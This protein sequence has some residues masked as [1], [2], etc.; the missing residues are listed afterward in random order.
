[1]ESKWYTY[2]P[3]ATHIHEIHWTTQIWEESLFSFLQHTLWLVMG[4]V[5]KWAKNLG[6]PKEKSTKFPIFPSY[7]SCNFWIYNSH[8][9]TPYAERLCQGYDLG[10]VE[11]EEHLLL[12][13][14]N[15]QK[16][17][18]RF[19]LA[20]PLTHTN[21]LVEFMQTTNIVALAK[22]MACCQYQRIICPPWSTF[23]LMDSLVPN[24]R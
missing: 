5:L 19:C 16:I 2:E 12:V 6:I 24:G 15:T 8:I 10:K 17:R 3:H 9:P 7:A 14:P 1:M 11:D 22:F 20:L 18:E 13:C 4:I 21:T 23:R